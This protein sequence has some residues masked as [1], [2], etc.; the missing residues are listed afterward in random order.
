M[1]DPFVCY[2][3]RNGVGHPEVINP[4]NPEWRSLFDFLQHVEASSST[5]IRAT[6]YPA[7]FYAWRTDERKAI[8]AY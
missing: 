8:N 5:Y 2:I 7:S 4:N 3:Q 1:E 6:M